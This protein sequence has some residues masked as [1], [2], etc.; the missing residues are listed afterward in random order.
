M[1]STRVSKIVT[2][3]PEFRKYEREY[4]EDDEAL[5]R[6]QRISE[7]YPDVKSLNNYTYKKLPTFNGIEEGEF[8]MRDLEREIED[9][10]DQIERYEANW[11]AADP[12]PLR[13]MEAAKSIEDGKLLTEDEKKLMNGHDCPE[14]AFRE[15]HEKSLSAITLRKNHIFLINERLIKMGAKLNIY[16]RVEVLEKAVFEEV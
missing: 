2:K 6:E 4:Y 1:V 9:I 12:A 14:R 16:E 11:M 10:Q 5:I 8:L 3:S 7:G 13:Y 15:W